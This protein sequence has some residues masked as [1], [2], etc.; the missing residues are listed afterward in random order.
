M[1]RSDWE[2]L[3]EVWE[4]LRMSGSC[5]ETLLNVPDW[6]EAFPDI[7]QWSRGPPECPGVVGRPSQ[8]SGSY[9]EALRMSRKPSQMSRSGREAV[10]HLRKWSGGPP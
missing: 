4:A 6:W 7:Q 1:S 8:M 2:S 5:R 9:R 10:P 3:Q